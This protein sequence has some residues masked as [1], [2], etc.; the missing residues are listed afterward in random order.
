MKPDVHEIH[1]GA[2]DNASGTAGLLELAEAFAAHSDQLKRSVVFIAFSGEE[3]GT[4]G[5]IYYV[6]HPSLPLDSAIAMV[7]MDMIGRMKDN[8]L[9]VNGTGTSSI[10]DSL[11]TRVNTAGDGHPRMTLKTVA[12]GYGPSDHA[13]FYKKDMPVLFL[14]TGTHEDYHKPSD[15]W[16]KLD[17]TGE[18]KVVAFTHD[19]V[20]DL[21]QRPDRP[22][23][24]KTQAAGP[25]AGGDGRGFT[26]TLGVIPDYAWTG[27][28]MKID[29]VRSKG[30]AETAGLK[31]GDVIVSLAG[32]KV[33][34][35]YDYMGILGELKAGQ[36]VPVSVQ[37][38][39]EVITVTATM[40]K[41]R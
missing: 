32:K 28:G 40:T 14:F 13:S 31:G 15:D 33:M 4:L 16:D 18:Q 17:Y 37:R 21:A 22:D 23:F 25:M 2:D 10:W 9:T 19:I 3:L 8:T 29:G 36:E 27:E 34:N 24:K 38:G 35:I 12:D 5:S 39:G 7:N 26:V 6:D 41:R 20:L 11:I 1:N 30:P